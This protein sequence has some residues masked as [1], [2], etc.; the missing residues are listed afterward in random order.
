MAGEGPTVVL[1]HGYG[2][3]LREWNVVW[4]A[5]LA[6]GHRVI[7][8]DQRGHGRSITGSDGI[9]SKPMAADLAAI[10]E[11]FDVSDAV[12]VAHSLGG[13]IAIRALLDHADLARRLRGCVLVATWAGRMLDGAPLMRLLA[14]LGQLGILDRLVRTR[15]GGLLFGA[16]QLGTHPS[17]AMISAMLEMF[18][19]QDHKALLPIGLAC[20]SEDRYPRLG[21]ITVPTVV[22]TGQVVAGSQG[23]PSASMTKVSKKFRPC[24]A[25]VD[26]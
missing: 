15:T 21:E 14:P 1:T 3:T 23:W 18:I 5:L 9:G 24:L 10:F 13:F 7:A 26:R 11:H 8:F 19:E 4:D 25:A 20:R 2:V 12:L 22:V 6:T 17:P 16:S